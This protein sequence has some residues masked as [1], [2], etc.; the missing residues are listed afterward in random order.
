[1]NT[2]A[3]PSLNPFGMRTY[4]MGDFLK[5]FGMNTCAKYPGGRGYIVTFGDEKTSL[6]LREAML[7]SAEAFCENLS[8]APHTT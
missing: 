6:A 4:A 3:I 7:A 2:Y 5:S 1:M 8:H